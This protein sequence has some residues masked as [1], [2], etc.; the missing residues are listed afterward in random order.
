MGLTHFPNGLNAGD[1]AGNAGTLAIGGTAVTATA[2]NLNTLATQTLKFRAGT[3]VTVA[4]FNVGTA[5]TGLSTVNV[6]TA[7]IEAA[8]TGLS[9]VAVG[10]ANV[11]GGTVVFALYGTASAAATTAGTIHWIAAGT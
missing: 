4:P 1:S 8:G 2:A 5:V 3:V 11:I 7:S 9:K 6:I 10:T